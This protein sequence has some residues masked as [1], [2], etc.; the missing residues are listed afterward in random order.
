MNTVTSDKTMREA[1]EQELE[2]NAQ[3][4]PSHIAVTAN[5]GAIVLT[6]HVPSYA[7][8]WA[9]VKAAERVYGVR[10]VAEEIEVRL[11]GSSERDDSDIAEDITRHMQSNLAIPDGVKAEVTGGNV[12]LLGQ[13]TK[14]YERVE[15]ER[16]LRH[17]RGVRTLVNMITVKPTEPK[18]SD[19]TYRISHAIE[20]MAHLD[21]R[22]IWATTTGST[23]RLHG[24]VRSFSEKHMAELTAAS[25]PGVTK[26]ENDISVTP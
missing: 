23:V 10:T 19:V 12:T 21:A 2:W 22:S 8:R 6:G 15:A 14:P 1:I 11:P 9:T 20:R 4:D 18:A 5:D 17:L 3:V 24:H 16:I 25:A 26:V 7:D 13:V